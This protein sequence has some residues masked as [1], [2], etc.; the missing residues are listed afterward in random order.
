MILDKRVFAVIPARGGSKGIPRKN[1][2]VVGG[3]PL[4]V[5]T[6]EA[7]R[8]SQYLDKIVVSSED[9]EILSVAQTWGAEPLIRPAELS[10][11]E[12][13][14]IEPVLHAIEA[15]MEYDY[16]VLL[17][18]TSPQRSTADIDGAI[19]LCHRMKAPACVSVCEASQSPYWMFKV[20]D[21]LKLAPL[22]P[23][24]LPIRR[25]DLPPVYLL[26]G[27]VYVARVEWLIDNKNFISEETIAHIMPRDRSLDIDMESDL[28]FFE[29]L[30]G[31]R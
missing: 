10:Q 8:R 7:A 4:I 19:E 5:Y 29:K 24:R 31:W 18:P 20:G 3:K 27:A 26:N 2:R 28:E 17:Q 15:N 25:Q 11:D 22:A 21:D 16:V 30:M 6:I 23:G 12:T 9:S 13:P 1:I 14:G